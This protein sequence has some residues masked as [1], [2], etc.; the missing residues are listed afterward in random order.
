[1]LASVVLHLA[2]VLPWT[3]PHSR[4]GAQERAPLSRLLA[5][6]DINEAVTRLN[7][8]VETEDYEAAAAIRD[9]I[10]AAIKADPMKQ[11]NSSLSLTWSEAPAWLSA[12]LED[13]GFRY[14][15]PVQAAALS[16]QNAAQVRECAFL[17]TVSHR[18][19]R[20][21]TP[22]CPCLALVTAA[23]GANGPRGYIGV[24]DHIRRHC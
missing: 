23:A 20:S 3:P 6:F 17:D 10:D 22:L 13:L 4:I 2:F 21:L 9:E 19:A 24:V 16:W 18:A 11:G 1:M 5:A 7:A 14:P 15:T 8:A 12:R